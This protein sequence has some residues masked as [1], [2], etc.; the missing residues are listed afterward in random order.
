MAGVRDERPC[1]H[2]RV[3][4]TFAMIASLTGTG[5]E[6]SGEGSPNP[7]ESHCLHDSAMVRLAA[8][9]ILADFEGF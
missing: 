5:R 9:L 4:L 1:T 7:P 3:D 8:V 2:P 6:Q